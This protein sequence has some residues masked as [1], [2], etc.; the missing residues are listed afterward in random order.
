MVRLSKIYTKTGD[1]GQTM[2]GD[3]SMTPKT[4]PRVEA[5][6]AVDEAN[7]AIGSAGVVGGGLSDLLRAL[8]NDLF[9]V[10]ADLCTPITPD[11]K[12]GDRLRISERDAE[13]IERL[14]DEHNER[15]APLTSFV[16]PGGTELS[17][18]LHTARVLVRR[19][20]RRVAELLEAEPGATNR[21]AFV[22]V[23]RLSDL[24]FVL[25]RRANDD[26]AL[27]VLWAPGKSAGVGDE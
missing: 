8:T 1:G 6:G 16:L 11:E 15:L 17:A 24:L 18:R 2:L 25:A 14:I 23:N 21:A 3:G 4:S 19:A 9:D 7:A 10:G 5:V 12:P 27:D 20:E 22:F 26:G 13:R